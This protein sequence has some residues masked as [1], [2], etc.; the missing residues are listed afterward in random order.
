MR[1]QR[2]MI[3][4]NERKFKVIRSITTADCRGNILDL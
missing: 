3:E 2:K 4:R 1:W